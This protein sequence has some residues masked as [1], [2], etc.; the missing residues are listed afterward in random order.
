MTLRH[1]HLDVCASLQTQHWDEQ[2]RAVESHAAMCRCSTRSRR[3]QGREVLS[4]N[5]SQSC[6]CLGSQ[7][8]D[9]AV[10]AARHQLAAHAVHPPLPDKVCS[11]LRHPAGSQLAGLCSPTYIGD[12]AACTEHSCL[13]G[14]A[15]CPHGRVAQQ[16]IPDWCLLFEQEVFGAVEQ[17]H[18]LLHQGSGQPAHCTIAFLFLGFACLQQGSVGFRNGTCCCMSAIA[19]A[20]TVVQAGLRCF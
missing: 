18:M 6:T 12:Q 2:I 15:A 5:S 20:R 17:L 10:R 14:H 8:Q 7:P 4:Q 11:P 1:C 13:H 3:V 19:K 16:C 9:E